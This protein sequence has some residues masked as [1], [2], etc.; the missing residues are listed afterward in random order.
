[1]QTSPDFPVP[2]GL[3]T[4]PVNTDDAQA[5]VDVL[6][7]IEQLEPA[8]E[9]WGVDD[10]LEQMQSPG[11][12]LARHSIGVFDEDRLVAFGVLMY[13]PPT[14]A[15]RGY[16]FGG[17]HP[18]FGHRRIGTAIVEALGRHGSVELRDEIDPSLPGE[19][20]IWRH[21]SRAATAALADSRG[22]ETWRW[23]F[24]MQR[25]LTQPIALGTGADGY[26]LRPYRSADEAAV[27]TV[28][29]LSFADHWGSSEMDPERWTA[30]FEGSTTFRPK[31][32]RVAVGPDGAVAA[33]V[34]V[35]EFVS[36]TKSRG[37]ATGYISLVGTLREARGRGLASALVTSAC[38]RALP[39][40][41]YRYA[42]LGVDAESP[43]GA[44]RIY[45][46]LGFITLERDTVAG[47][48]F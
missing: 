18:E 13:S 15:F 20:K 41:G 36:D 44:G 26:L 8:D 23:F 12:D 22:F 16:L 9:N 43:T 32:S 47:R 11:V 33:F 28:R 7:A 25:D 17:V 30:A 5:I 14:D 45:E 2:P 37:Y 39:T 24:R 27:R 19:L 31:H 10:V 46:R 3:T 42:E 48:R 34:V 4:R 38:S 1:M 21:G 29:N 40:D 6:E 35:Q